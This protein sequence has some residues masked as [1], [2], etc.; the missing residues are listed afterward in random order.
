MGITWFNPPFNVGSFMACSSTMQTCLE[1]FASKERVYTAE[2][3]QRCTTLFIDLSAL[4]LS[5]V[6][7][8]PKGIRQ[9]LREKRVRSL[10]THAISSV[11]PSQDPG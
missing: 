10:Q 9:Q 3:S 4:E 6:L 11:H 2:L 1:A 5:L 7:T 8:Q